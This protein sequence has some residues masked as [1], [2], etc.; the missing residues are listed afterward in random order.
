MG[1]RAFLIRWDLPS[2]ATDQ[3]IGY[4]ISYKA[5]DD[6]IAHERKPQI[7]DPYVN[8][9]KLTGLKPETKYQLYVAACT[10]NGTGER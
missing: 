5:S 3:L 2:D 6:N 1:S 9:T 4:N 8:Q 7:Q 10:R